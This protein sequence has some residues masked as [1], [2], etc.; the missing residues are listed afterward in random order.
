MSFPPRGRWTTLPPQSNSYASLGDLLAG[1]RK[2]SILVVDDSAVNAALLNDPKVL[3]AY[4]G[5]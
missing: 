3:A 5:G 4:M 1:R 2:Q